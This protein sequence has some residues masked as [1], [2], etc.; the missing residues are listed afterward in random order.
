MSVPKTF[1]LAGRIAYQLLQL[2]PGQ[3]FITR[4]RHES[5]TNS[6][7]ISFATTTVTCLFTILLNLL[8][9]TEDEK[10]KK[11]SNILLS[12]VALADLLLG[13]VSMSLTITLDTV[14]WQESFI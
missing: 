1:L 3:C 10:L 9:T 7:Y 11:N 12:C 6:F 4:S 8:L 5:H 13:A 14:A 2:K